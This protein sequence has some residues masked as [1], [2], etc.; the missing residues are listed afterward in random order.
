MFAQ[1][2]HSWLQIQ[3]IPVYECGGKC[4]KC[5]IKEHQYALPEDKGSIGFD[6]FNG[7]VKLLTM[8]G[9]SKYGLST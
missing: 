1:C 9:E 3:N 6:T 8:R 4:I 2:H 5:L 7:I